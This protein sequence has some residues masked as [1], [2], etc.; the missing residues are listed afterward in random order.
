MNTKFDPTIAQQSAM[1]DYIVSAVV[2]DATGESEGDRCVGEPPSAKYYLATLAPG[3]LNLAVG[4]TRRGRSTPSALGFEFEV[5]TPEA[6]LTLRAS[7]SCYYSVFPTLAEQLQFNPLSDVDLSVVANVRLAPVFAR[8]QVETGDLTVRLDPARSLQSFGADEFRNAFDHAAAMASRDPMVDRRERGD[9]RERRVPAANL[10]SEEAFS[11]FLNALPGDPIIPTWSARVSVSARP[12][13]RGRV[14][15]SLMV[16]NLSRD[17]VFERLIQGRMQE[18]HDDARDHFLFQVRLEVVAD[19]GVIVPIEMDLGPDAYRYDRKLA[20]YATNCGI[21][22]S[23]KAAGSI[24]HIWSVAAPVTEVQRSRSRAHPATSFERLAREPLAATREFAATM[25]AYLHH[26]DWSM[27]GLPAALAARKQADMDAYRQEVARFEDGVRWLDKDE[28]LL[29]AFV[30]ANRTMTKL[31]E[32][33]H[34]NRTMWRPFQLVFIVSQ[35]SSLAWREHDPSEFTPNLWGDPDS[36]DPTAAATVLWF[37]TAGGKTEAYLGLIACALFYDRAR[38]KSVGVTAWSRFPLRL[39]T[40]DQAARQLALVVAAD[41]VRKEASSE[42]TR[43]GGG[44]GE[45]YALGFFAGERNSPNSL[46]RDPGLVDRLSTDPQR[47]QEVRLIDGCPYCL[48]QNVQVEPPDPVELVLVHRCPD[49]GRKLPLYIVD[50][51]IYRYLPAVIVG[52]LDKLALIGLSDKFGAILG[53]VDCQC[54]LHGFGRGLKCH[55]RRAKGHPR[56]P[57]PRL[58]APLYDA[59]PSLEIVDEL[60]LVREELGAFSG[61]YEGL[62]STLQ[63]DLTARSRSDGR[64]VRM[65]VVATTATIRGEDRQCEHLFG[66]RSVVVPLPGPILGRSLYAEVDP[67][68]PMRRFVGILPN[69]ATAEL[70]Q[71]RI[72]TSIHAA[73]R[74][75]ETDGPTGLAGLGRI[76]PEQFRTLLDLYRVSITYVT[77]LV[78]LGKLRRSMDTQVNE[79][80]RRQGMR[81]LVV[82]DLSGDADIDKLRQVRDSLIT[83]GPVESVVV[84]SMFSHGV[85]IDR[86]NV[87]LFNGMPKSMAEYIQASSRVGRRFLGVVFM[88]FNPIRERDRSHFR[89]HSKFHEYIDRMVEPVAIN[90]WS[91]YA[92]RK[93]LPG[94]LM[95]YVLQE[96]NRDY[97]DVG[98]APRHLHE[99]V[100][101]QEALRPVESGGVAGAHKTAILKALHRAYLVDRDEAAELRTDIDNDVELALSYIRSAGAAAGAAS[102]GRPEYR[103]TGEH[104]GLAYEPMT[105]LRDVA[106]GLPFSTVP[107]RK[108]S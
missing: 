7:A 6:T 75:L 41:E 103:G 63:T 105:S 24:G 11:S 54:A 66:L 9:R 74:R 91:R 29:A 88:L 99:L 108:R 12:V 17:P 104:L 73:I 1:A 68:E 55:E 42:L 77:S 3:D 79:S 49:C 28:R 84:T 80:L 72:L 94:L 58:D 107:E 25:G 44:P 56:G 22:S 36:G 27:A 35:L 37:P 15:V 45:P 100:N 65:K 20:A 39:L 69:R 40:L 53:D 5:T 59:S 93:T 2:T 34:D 60:H 14:R 4:R 92:A 83:S 76:S 71:V 8:V 18:R 98:R 31:A 19:D 62:L 33:S 70:A 89:Y 57:L 38:G 46:S 101:M 21:A 32:M 52:T 85:D 67:E 90:R 97:W 48:G 64:G 81:E 10:G 26:A 23:R 86:L 61:H 43:L 50:S 78:D 16:E 47:R 51:E 13:S 106:E 82:K 30:L 87:M 96:A 102:R 95:G